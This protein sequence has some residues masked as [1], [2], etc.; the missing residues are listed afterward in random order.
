MEMQAY[1]AFGTKEPIAYSGITLM[2]HWTGNWHHYQVKQFETSSSSLLSTVATSS[3]GSL[4]DKYRVA[5][6]TINH[7][8]VKSF[9][10]IHQEKIMSILL[11]TLA[12]VRIEESMG[13][14]IRMLSELTDLLPHK[15]EIPWE[16][17]TEIQVAD[18]GR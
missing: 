16:L 10:R 6:G 2:I 14:H 18:Q 17:I 8:K 3:Q 11:K 9:T 7:T 12:S 5:F 4:L 13:A 15:P 1:K